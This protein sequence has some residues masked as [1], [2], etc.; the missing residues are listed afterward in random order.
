VNFNWNSDEIIFERFSDNI[1]TAEGTQRR[2]EPA[3]IY[4]QLVNNS[5]SRQAAVTY[6]TGHPHRLE[7]SRDTEGQLSQ[8][9]SNLIKMLKERFITF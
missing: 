2:T 4:I 6:F 8:T 7:R 9:V 5:V 1:S 3:D